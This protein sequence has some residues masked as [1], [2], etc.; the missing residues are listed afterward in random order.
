MGKFFETFFFQETTSS[1]KTRVCTLPSISEDDE[2]SASDDEDEDEKTNAGEKSGEEEDVDQTHV[3]PSVNSP[4]L[5]PNRMFQKLPNG[6]IA[7]DS[8]NR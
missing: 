3:T 5:P 4:L 6:D 2:L 8:L 1:P 7:V